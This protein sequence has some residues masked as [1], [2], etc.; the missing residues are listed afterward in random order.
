MSAIHLLVASVLLSAAPTKAVPQS[1]PSDPTA[2]EQRNPDRA[3]G[4][5]GPDATGRAPL[6]GEALDSNDHEPE[7]T[8]AQLVPGVGRGPIYPPGPA[9]RCI[10]GK[11][12]LRLF[13]DSEGIVR[14]IEIELSS[15]NRQLDDAAISAAATW[16]FTPER[17]NGMPVDSVM[18]FPISFDTPSWC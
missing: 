1:Q 8:F 18:L 6:D 2:A 16:R 3:E 4:S 9:R 14:K 10:D 11:V 15:G 12:M 17:R 13:I 7:I 5:A